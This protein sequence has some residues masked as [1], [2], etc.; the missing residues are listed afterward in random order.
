[1]VTGT[2]YNERGEAYKTVDPAAREHRQE[3]DHAGRTT[4]TI[5]NYVDGQVDGDHPDCDV[6]VEMAYNADGQVLSLTA[7]NPA[8]GNQVTRYVYG[9][10]LSDS[11]VARADLLRAEIYPDSEDTD[12]EQRGRE[13]LK[14]TRAWSND[15]LPP[16]HDD[17]DS[18][19]GDMS[20]M[21]ST[22]LWGA[23]AFSARRGIT[24]RSRRCWPRPKDACRWENMP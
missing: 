8:T 16:C 10:T 6:T 21:C 3:S 7:L 14:L 15:I 22:A 12:G 20:T 11:D 19:A 24:R 18:P 13:S 5:R 2:V 1:M 9:T 4:R 23:F 17:C